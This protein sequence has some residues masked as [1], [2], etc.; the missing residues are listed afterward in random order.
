MLTSAWQNPS[1]PTD[2]NG[3]NFVSAMDVLL[4]INELHVRQYSLDGWDIDP[5]TRVEPASVTRELQFEVVE[6]RPE[7][8]PPFDWYQPLSEPIFQQHQMNY[9]PTVRPIV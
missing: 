7:P 3:D 5:R 4:V 9:E 2:V 8:E 1:Q 6:G